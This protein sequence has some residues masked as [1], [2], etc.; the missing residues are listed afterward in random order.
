M[1]NTHNIDIAV[2]GF[3][4]L[5]AEIENGVREYFYVDFVGG[6]KNEGEL[7]AAL[8]R[9]AEIQGLAFE[10]EYDDGELVIWIGQREYFTSVKEDF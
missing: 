10:V 6:M 5:L 8:R 7:I 4:D 2:R 1:A 3:K 9:E